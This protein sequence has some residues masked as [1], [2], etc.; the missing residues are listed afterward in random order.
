MKKALSLLLVLIAIFSTLTSCRILPDSPV[1]PDN[2]GT[3][4]TDP[5]D[6][7]DRTNIPDENYT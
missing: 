3:T 4:P 5:S 6:P 1:D 7:S 2:G